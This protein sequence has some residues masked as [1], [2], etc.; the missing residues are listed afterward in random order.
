MPDVLDQKV[1]APKNITVSEWDPSKWKNTPSE[2]AIHT[3]FTYADTEARKAVAWYERAKHRKAM[4]SG[5]LRAISIVLF[6]I[7]GLAPILAGFIVA[8]SASDDQ[9]M[10]PLDKLTAD[11]PTA[12][13]NASAVSRSFQLFLSSS[14]QL[15]RTATRMRFSFFGQYQRSLIKPSASI[16]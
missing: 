16:G 1:L 7:G 2:G 4:A 5:A 3:L 10:A 6:V 13:R 15:P 8:G 12:A 9:T 14:L 11:S